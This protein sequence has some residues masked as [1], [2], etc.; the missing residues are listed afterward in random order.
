MS[1]AF[2]GKLEKITGSL[3]VIV[4]F[5]VMAI[6]A[7]IIIPLPSGLLD[8]MLVINIAL[9]ITILLL[10]LFTK[11]VLEFSTFPTI[12]L[13]TTMFRLALNISSTRLILTEGE[14]GA[15]IETFAN[16]VAGSNF[17]VGAVIFIIIVII[18]MMVVTNG[19]SRVSEV[20]ARFTLD[21]MP[22]KQMAIDADLNSGLINE[23]Q[24]KKRRS[25]LE[26]E[27]QFF[28]AMDGASKFVKGDAMAGIIITVINLIG[29]VAIH[30]LQ[31][32]MPIM[33]AL[34]TFGKLTI[35]DGLVSQIPSLLISVAS[36]ILV[37]RSGSLKGFGSS[38]GEELFGSS[39]VMMML[40][41]ILLLFA[42]MP[43]FP[44]IPF[45][46]LGVLSGAAGYLLMENEKSQKT[47]QK[48]KEMRSMAAQRTK[49]EKTV[50]E[51]VASFQVDPI[52]IEIGYGLIPIADENQD[53]NL[54]SHIT[55]IR[56][57]SAHE[58]GIL[59]SPI[60]IRDNL[61]LKANDYVIKIKGNVIARGE[62]YL[63]KYMI[64]DPGETEF[65]FD[66]IPTKEPAFGL[67]AMWVNESDREV[68]DLRGYTVVD[69]ITV[70][71]THLKETIYKS[72]YEL[73]G[74]QEVK[75]LLEGIK[76]KYGVVIDELIPD[77][78]RLGEVQK[79]LQN[80][81][82]E[83]IPINDLVTI[84]ETLADYGNTTK[85]SE[86]LTEYVRQA[87]KRTVVKPYL[88]EQDVLQ[89]VT[90]LPDTEELITRSIQKSSAG[91][92]PI[93]QPDTVTKIFDSITAI[94]NQL[95][96]RGIPHVLLA[97]PK[98]RPALKNLLTY[99]F[100]DL[101]VVSLN[102]VPNDVPIETVGMIE[103]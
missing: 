42:I 76:D 47:N 62:L 1:T 28:G 96:A 61:Q 68:A 63:D 56:K 52:S 49:S 86:M 53:N 35:G 8:L 71:V 31:N 19:S 103:G 54:M 14:A 18:Q 20:S 75:Q 57:Q 85:D 74:R 91:S 32:G 9:S 5:F 80:L 101:A 36:G 46:L 84:L 7:M 10:T 38:M 40:S 33:E 24:A 67:D 64:V 27:T 43:G 6:L 34:M 41:V 23:E 93:L 69:P 94:H 25:D 88:N 82:K 55:T 51:S 12:L 77:I 90:I 66:G 95:S 97:S 2:W 59:L 98:V 72:S 65:D 44:T 78:L 37:T 87:L 3:D 81:L 70:L 16:F 58:L 83:N 48:A 21:A 92:I 29:G 99:N 17:V 73:L 50:D 102:E 22:G 79:V 100:P 13:I 4:A 39:K 89:V 30:S 26:R 11:N 45:L 15:V 60:R